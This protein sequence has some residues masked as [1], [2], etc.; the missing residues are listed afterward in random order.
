MRVTSWQ[1]LFVALSLIAVVLFVAVLTR[2]KET[3]RDED[4]VTGGWS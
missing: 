4:R 3:L 1:G 2:L